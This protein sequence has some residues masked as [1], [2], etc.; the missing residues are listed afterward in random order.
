MPFNGGY[1]STEKVVPCVLQCSEVDYSSNAGP[2]KIIQIVG[3]ISF[4]LEE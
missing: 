4:D 1:V 3:R 2:S